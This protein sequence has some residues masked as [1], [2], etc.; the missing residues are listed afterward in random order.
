M[1][2]VTDP[3]DR[4]DNG[5]ATQHRPPYT[6]LAW[7]RR[8]PEVFNQGLE[9]NPVID[10][11]FG[12]ARTWSTPQAIYGVSNWKEGLQGRIIKCS[13]E[14]RKTGVVLRPIRA[15]YIIDISHFESDVRG[16]ALGSGVAGGT[17][18][19]GSFMLII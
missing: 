11:Q 1:S 8:R 10:D 13:P 6:T 14:L 9:F 18:S 4:T 2:W 7:R 19:S 15:W 12:E 16:G 17:N 5:Q 3:Q